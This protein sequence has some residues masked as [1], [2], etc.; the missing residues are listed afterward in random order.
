MNVRSGYGNWDI[1]VDS[2]YWLLCNCHV[3]FIY[4]CMY[5]ALLTFQFKGEI[6]IILWTKQAMPGIELGI[7]LLDNRI[8]NTSS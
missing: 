2:D 7:N 1:R 4:V 8:L 5:T 6:L 3:L